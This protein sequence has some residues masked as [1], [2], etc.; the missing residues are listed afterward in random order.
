MT[1]RVSLD[2]MN[3][4]QLDQL[5]AD[6]D[7]ARRELADRHEGDSADAAAGSYASA[8]ATLTITVTAPDQVHAVRWAG[9][10]RD[11]VHNEY[12]QSMRLHSFIELE[13]GGRTGPAADQCADSLYRALDTLQ[14]VGERCDTADD[15]HETIT[16]SDVRTWL[17]G[18]RCGR[19]AAAEQ[20]AQATPDNPNNATVQRVTDLYERWVAAGPPPLGTSMSRWWDRRLAEL[21]AALTP[22]EPAPAATEATDTTKAVCDCPPTHAGLELCPACPGRTKE[23]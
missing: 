10:I 14:F 5:Y 19:E 16:T 23:N 15:L 17:R 3:S 1:D 6:L 20:R 9:H 11:L 2:D 12:G 18:T 22:T 8:Q 13:P 7:R 21:H 4:N